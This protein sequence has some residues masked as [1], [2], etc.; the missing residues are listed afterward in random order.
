MRVFGSTNKDAHILR[1]ITGTSGVVAEDSQIVSLEEL[2]GY[3]GSDGDLIIPTSPAG[4]PVTAVGDF[5]FYEFPGRRT[6]L[7]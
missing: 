4:L 6:A 1:E 7:R 2:V 3:G 5:A